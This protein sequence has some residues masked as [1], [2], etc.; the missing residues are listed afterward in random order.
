MLCERCQKN[1]ANVHITQY[2]NGQKTEKNLCD[3]CAQLEQVGMNFPKTPLYDLLGVFFKEPLVKQKEI[4]V[5]VCPNCGVSY[6][7]I[8]KLGRAGC[9]V[10][11]DHFS[12]Y[13]EPALRKMHGATVHH[14]KIP[15]RLGSS[16]RVDRQIKALKEQLKLAIEKEAYEQAVVL[17]DKIKELEKKHQ[18]G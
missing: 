14:G 15:L 17:R 18:E 8:A 10:C 16:L 9:S 7:Q 11:Y 12:A 5:D 1:P 4:Q 13:L 6:R 2:I 3:E